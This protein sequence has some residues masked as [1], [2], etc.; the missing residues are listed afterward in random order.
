MEHDWAKYVYSVVG[1]IE[2][3][4]VKHKVSCASHELLIVAS[5]CKVS[6]YS[7]LLKVHKLLRHDFTWFAFPS[8]DSSGNTPIQISNGFGELNDVIQKVVS[9]SPT[10]D[11][12][13]L[14][15]TFLYDLDYFRSS[16]DTVQLQLQCIFIP[17]LPKVTCSDGQ[18]FLLCSLLFVCAGLSECS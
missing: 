4:C 14:G 16:S 13:F 3:S 5:V 18:D 15:G 6:S 2:I 7:T 17:F 11:A 8:R 10:S 12:F 1:P 9:I